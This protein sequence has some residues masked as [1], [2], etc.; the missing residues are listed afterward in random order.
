MTIQNMIINPYD[1]LFITLE[2][3][4]GSGKTTQAERLCRALNNLGHK[5][6]I[7]KEPYTDKSAELKN[8]PN[9]TRVQRQTMFIE[10]SLEHISEA[11]IPSLNKDE[12]VIS[13]RYRDSGFAYW[14]GEG[15]K[16]E[17]ILDLHEKILSYV[18]IMPNLTFFI[19]TDVDVALERMKG[20]RKSLGYFETSEKMKRNRDGYLWLY[21]QP[22]WSE[23]GRQI[24]IIRD[25]GKKSIDEISREILSKT[26]PFFEKK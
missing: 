7:T 18:F 19:D 24:E 25:D 20:S 21:A 2:G 15:G 26:L 5:T 11:I 4:D 1:A 16:F 8:N 22:M 3:L 17:E 14:I 23:I 12:N 9:L 6:V 13:D 10:D